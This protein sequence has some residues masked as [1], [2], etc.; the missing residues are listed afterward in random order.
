MNVSKQFVHTRLQKWKNVASQWI[1]DEADNGP[2]TVGPNVELEPDMF[3]RCRQLAEARG[4]T[5]SSVVHYMLKQQLALRGQER[6]VRPSAEMLERNPLLAL[7]GLAG[8][9]PAFDAEVEEDE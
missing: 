4:T 5:V 9:R 3:E 7:D 8:Q 2:D 1:S 6:L